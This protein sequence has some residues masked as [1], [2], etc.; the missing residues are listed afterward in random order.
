MVVTARKGRGLAWAELL[1]ACRA[2]AQTPSLNVGGVVNSG[3][4][5]SWGVAPGSIASL[6]GANLAGSQVIAN[7]VPLPANLGSVTSVTFN[8]VAAP[9]N[10]VAGGQIDV[11]VPWTV[12]AGTATVVVNTASGAS[13][14]QSVPVV[15]A[16]PDIFTISAN[17]IG[18]AT[19]TDNADGAIAGPTGNIGGFNA[20]PIHAGEYLIVRCTGLG[21]VDTP[22]ANGANT[23]GAI[24]NT[25]AKPAV[26]IGGVAA[27][28]VYS[29]LS[30]APRRPRA[31]RPPLAGIA[32]ASPE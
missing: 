12:A 19:A 26:S 14:P 25:V 1:L 18:Q 5:A 7:A 20:H 6:F 29:V 8:G 27:T 3:S 24:V 28:P 16:M 10:F 32:V 13:A 30:P 21:A 4:Y 31:C 23:G 17:G 22:L 2:G 9:L 11:Q 15:A